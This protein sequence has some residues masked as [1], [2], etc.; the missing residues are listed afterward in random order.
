MRSLGELKKGKP[1]TLND[2]EGAR[3]WCRGGDDDDQLGR[4]ARR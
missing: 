1:P 4:E 3:K 2:K